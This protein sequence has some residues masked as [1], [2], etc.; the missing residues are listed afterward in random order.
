MLPFC[1]RA[2]YNS[3]LIGKVIL[4][5]LGKKFS[6]DIFEFK[7]CSTDLLYKDVDIRLVNK[8]YRFDV[9]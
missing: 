5:S 8:I 4:G 1:V 6:D 7:T 9:Y 3:G 2:V